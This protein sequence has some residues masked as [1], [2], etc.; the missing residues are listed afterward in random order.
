MGAEVMAMTTC[1]AVIRAN[2][3]R[4]SCD[5]RGSCHDLRVRIPASAGMTKVFV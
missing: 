5:G 2:A 3:E 1:L 4:D